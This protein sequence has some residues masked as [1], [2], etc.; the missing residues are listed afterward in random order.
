MEK[1]APVARFVLTVIAP[2]VALVQ[3]KMIE[4]KAAA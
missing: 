3:K 2:K 1:P 4:V